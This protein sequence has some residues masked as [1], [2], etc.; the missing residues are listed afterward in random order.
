MSR[1]WTT[2]CEGFYRRDFL[3]LGAAGLFGLTLP[4]LLRLEAQAAHF[5]R[6]ARDRHA[7][8]MLGHQPADGVDVVVLDRDPA[9]LFQVVDVEA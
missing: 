1:D 2:D 9:R 5:G 3:K 4:E 8:E 7:A 6:G